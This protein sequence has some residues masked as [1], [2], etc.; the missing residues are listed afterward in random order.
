MHDTALEGK[1]VR[2]VIGS[3][4]RDRI[5][6]C[7]VLNQLGIKTNRLKS[8]GLKERR[9]KKA[10]HLCRHSVP[11]MHEHYSTLEPKLC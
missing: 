10:C 7:R 11:V 8:L 9:K 2:I 4:L 5:A 3:K 1:V 6:K